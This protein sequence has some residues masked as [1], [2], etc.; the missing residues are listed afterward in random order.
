M[1]R[2]IVTVQAMITILNNAIICH[3]AFLNRLVWYIHQLQNLQ[4][5]FIQ[6]INLPNIHC[7]QHTTKLTRQHRLLHT[8]LESFRHLERYVI[9]GI[10]LDTPGRT[11]A[12]KQLRLCQE[13]RRYLLLDTA[14][15]QR[16]M[17]KRELIMTPNP[18]RGTFTVS[19]QS[20]MHGVNA[21]IHAV[22]LWYSVAELVW[23]MRDVTAM[24]E[25]LNMVN[26]LY[27][28][29]YAYEGNDLEAILLRL[30]QNLFF[31]N[32]FCQKILQKFTFMK[33]VQ[34]LNTFSGKFRTLF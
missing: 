19:G 27:E 21:A 2:K 10:I 22:E 6:I 4:G 7:S 5:L 31:P 13:M 28:E 17:R 11:L 16:K 20:G 34:S 9:R 33:R 1:D 29:V 32:F 3:R 24:E 8:R 23:A 25:Q 14:L 26:A 15:N 30:F 12:T 18:V